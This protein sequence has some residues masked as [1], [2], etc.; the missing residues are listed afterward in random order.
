MKTDSE[1]LLEAFSRHAL[2]KLIEEHVIGRLGGVNEGRP[3][4]L[5]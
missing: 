3:A 2:L 4:F 5:S 1:D